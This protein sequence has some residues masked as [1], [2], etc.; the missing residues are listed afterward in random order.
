MLKY[1]VKILEQAKDFLD[2]LDDRIQRKVIFNIWKSK[3]VND[4]RLFR[5]LSIEIWE[6]RTRYLVPLRKLSIFIK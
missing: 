4:P 3:E 2:K 6:F 5:K 1:E